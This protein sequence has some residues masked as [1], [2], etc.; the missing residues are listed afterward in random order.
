MK[1]Q[2]SHWIHVVEDTGQWQAVVK[3]VKSCRI[4]YKRRLFT[5]SLTMG[6]TR[7]TVL[8]GRNFKEIS[9]KLAQMKK[10]CS[11]P[12]LL[13]LYLEYL[14]NILAYYI[15]SPTRYTK[16]LNGW[17]YSALMLARLISNLTGPSSGVFSTSCI[18]RFGMWLYAYYSTRPAV[19]S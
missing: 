4:P 15:C 8:Y 12:A 1:V 7:G 3:R 19:T 14:I 2:D 9:R 5:C 13:C 17:V 18:R 6:F 16:C 10:Y 11:I